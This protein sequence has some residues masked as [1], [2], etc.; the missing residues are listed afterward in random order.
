MKRFHTMIGSA[1]MTAARFCTFILLL[2]CVASVSQIL[3]AQSIGRVGTSAAS[4]LKIGVGSR[5]LGMGEAYTTIAEDA[6]AMYWNPA[7]IAAGTQAQMI[8]SHYN[9]I[10]DINYDFGGVVVPMGDVGT[11]G[12][13]AGSLDYGEI[14]RTTVQS[15]NGTGEKVSAGSFVFGV[16]YGRALT[17]RF[18]IGGSVKY[19]R[20]SI[21]HSSADGI[22]V[23]IGVLYTTFFKNIKIGMSI[24]NFGTEMQMNGR[25]MLVQHDI[26]EPIAGNNEN[27]NA[28][29]DADK[30]PLPILFRIGL[31]SN[32]AKDFLGLEEYD[33]IVAADAVHPNDNYEYINVG[34]ELSLFKKLVS[35]RGGFRQLMLAEREGGLTLGA[36]VETEVNGSIINVDYAYVDLGRFDS[37]NKITIMLSF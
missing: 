22:A 18:K 13:F 14:E 8:Y 30:F 17:D 24:S 27:L 3:R 10:A 35:L 23:D 20:E 26:S 31:S 5:A 28:H 6:S 2:L 12:A 25:D 1:T 19:I 33:L 34:A 37:H 32:I 21:W 16:S 9:Y 4:F 11:F 36:G 7:G 15:P 29:L